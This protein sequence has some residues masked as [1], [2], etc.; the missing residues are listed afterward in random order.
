[1]ASLNIALSKPLLRSVEASAK[2]EWTARNRQ[3]R[4][5]L[6]ADGSAL[7]VVNAAFRSDR[8]GAYDAIAQVSYLDRHII[9]WSGK[10]NAA[11]GFAKASLDGKFESSFHSPV[12]VSGQ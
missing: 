10:I 9:N 2:Y 11:R 4:A 6:D 3:L 12:Y 7:A 8:P 1:M 5:S